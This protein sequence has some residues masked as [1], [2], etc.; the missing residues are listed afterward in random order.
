VTPFDKPNFDQYI[1]RYY[2]LFHANTHVNV[3]FVTIRLLIRFSPE[4]TNYCY[5]F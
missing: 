1:A 2:L 5:N 4:E 3:G